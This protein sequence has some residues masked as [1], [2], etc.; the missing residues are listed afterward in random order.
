VSYSQLLGSVGVNAF[1]GPY[2]LPH[3]ERNTQWTVTAAW[4]RTIPSSRVGA[5]LHPALVTAA[6]AQLGAAA[7]YGAFAV[8]CVCQ[9]DPKD[10]FSR[11]GAASLGTAP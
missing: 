7:V 1:A 6:P 10:P 4:S 9:Q 2:K 11:R 8:E 3:T 5:R